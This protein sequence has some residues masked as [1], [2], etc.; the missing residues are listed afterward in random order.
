MELVIASTNLH[1]IREF[2]EMMKHLNSI[3]LLSL[4]NF[5]AYKPLPEEALTFQDNAIQKAE[6]AAKSLNKWILADDSGLVVPAL[7]GARDPVSPLCRRRCHR[8]RK[9]TETLGGNGPPE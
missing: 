5:P 8:C 1:K 7:N 9:Q 3:D 2:R 6:H 4:H